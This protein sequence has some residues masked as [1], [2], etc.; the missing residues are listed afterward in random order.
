MTPAHLLVGGL[1][2]LDPGR[3][4]RARRRRVQHAAGRTDF[5]RARGVHRDLDRL[6]PIPISHIGG[7][8][9]KLLGCPAPARSDGAGVHD[10]FID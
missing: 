6:G 3:V 1:R 7:A 10:M 4:E 5:L 2:R 9:C 8:V